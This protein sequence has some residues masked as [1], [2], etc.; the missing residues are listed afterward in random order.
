MTDSRTSYQIKTPDNLF[1][2]RLKEYMKEQVTILRFVAD[3]TVMLYILIPGIL[4][5]ARLYYGL[6]VEDLPQW[7]LQVPSILFS[8][9]ML[10]GIYSGGILLLVQEGDALFI[11]MHH[12]WMSGIILRGS[13]YS[14]A[15]ILMKVV[16]LFAIV[17]PF[18]VRILGMNTFELTSF[19]ILSMATSWIVSWIR[20]FVTITF[21]GW[22]KRLLLICGIGIPCAL[23]ARVTIL[24]IHQP[25]FMI[26]TAV[27]L[28]VATLLFMK[29]RVHL[30]GTFM[31]DVQ[32]DSKQ[33]MKLTGF[34]LKQVVDKPMP[35]RTKPWIFRRSPYLYRS[36]SAEHR[37][38]AA[39]VK[40]WF[41]NPKHVLLYL[42]FTGVSLLAIIVPP[43]MIKWFVLLAVSMM[44][45]Y[46]LFRYW[47]HF[48]YDEWVS[49]L[50]W[51]PE[52]ALKA[53]MLAVRT[54]HLPYILVISTAF[55]LTLLG[56][57]W[58]WMLILPLT[59][60]MNRLSVYLF[61][62]MNYSKG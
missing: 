35:T 7:S 18:L 12:R 51:S 17:S 5:G 29:K 34:L 26:S 44:L 45:V 36:R 14:M 46:W 6:W 25:F 9:F 13:L 37:L 39:A 41:R 43:G 49:L 20:H 33:R 58:G 61:S 22:R 56:I 31:N 3:W 4:L 52:V 53:G 40:A 2:R 15:V 50:P 62:F 30:Q 54:M 24:W 59:L 42:Q 38:A 47:I 55:S 23:Y 1:W 32:E 19:L 60:V 21:S 10:L 57:G 11:R 28:I 8:S 48:L 27:L 16:I